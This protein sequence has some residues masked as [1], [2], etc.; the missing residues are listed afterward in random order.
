MSLQKLRKLDIRV[1]IKWIEVDM[2][3]DMLRT[4]APRPEDCKLAEDCKLD[5]SA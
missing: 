5:P 1:Y 3:L 4:K 2:Y